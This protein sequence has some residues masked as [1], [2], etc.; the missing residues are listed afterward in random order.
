M[1]L[2][3]MIMKDKR[4]GAF[5]PPQFT[6]KAVEVE[7]TN[8]GRALAIATKEKAHQYKGKELYC[9]G[10]FDDET[11]KMDLLAE[12]EFVLDCESIENVAN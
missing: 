12:P 9:L 10:T 11:G 2:N 4:L 3:I 5:C 1:K 7:K 6:D 8:L